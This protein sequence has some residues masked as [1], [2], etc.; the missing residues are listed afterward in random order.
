M[1]PTILLPELPD[2]TDPKAVKEYLAAHQKIL[3]DKQKS[4]Y[5]SISNL[6]QM[7]TAIISGQIGTAL[8]SEGLVAPITIPFNEFRNLISR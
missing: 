5:E 2:T 6:E 4:D 8:F 7:E 1:N 3:A